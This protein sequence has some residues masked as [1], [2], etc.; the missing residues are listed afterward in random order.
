MSYLHI[1]A[2]CTI[3][4]HLNSKILLR[5]LMHLGKVSSKSHKAFPLGIGEMIYTLLLPQAAR[6]VKH[7]LIRRVKHYLILN[8]K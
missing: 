8:N 4:G 2:S 6:R 3:G 1:S 7:Y 5:I